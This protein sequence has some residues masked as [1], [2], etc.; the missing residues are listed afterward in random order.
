MHIGDREPQLS[1]NFAGCFH[2]L[3]AQSFMPGTARQHE[4]RIKDLSEQIREAEHIASSFAESDSFFRILCLESG[5]GVLGI[6]RSFDGRN[7]PDSAVFAASQRI[8]GVLVRDYPGWRIGTLG[9]IFALGASHSGESLGC[10][11]KGV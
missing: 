11:E 4:G 7:A 2:T 1:L 3:L 8:Y 10:F 9:K 6:R 5:A